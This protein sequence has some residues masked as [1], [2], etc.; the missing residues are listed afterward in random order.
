MAADT[1]YI[2]DT[3]SL[4]D[5]QRWRPLAKHRVI[6]QKLDGLIRDGRLIGPEQVYSELRAG[7]DSL[8]KWAVSHKKGG[9]FFKKTTR[10]HVGIAKQIIHKYSD[11]VDVDRPGSQADPFVIAL[12][13]YEANS[14]TLAQQCIVVTNEKFTPTGRPRIPH[15]CAS[16][17]LPY[18]TIHQL[19]VTEGWAF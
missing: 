1:I 6:W 19:Y 16:Y 11:L 5:L 18:L 17:K 14:T 2:I 9:Q 12:A 10:Q 4:I 3:S 7:K 8:A 15:I 13:H